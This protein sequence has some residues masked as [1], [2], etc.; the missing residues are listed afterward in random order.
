MSEKPEPSTVPEDEEIPL[1]EEEDAT[2]PNPTEENQNEAEAGDTPLSEWTEIMS[3]LART[4]PPICGVLNGSRAF[5]KGQFL[6]IDAPNPMFRGMIN[7]KSSTYRDAIRKAAEQVLGQTYKL[8]PYKASATDTSN[9][10]LKALADKLKQ[11]D[12][13]NN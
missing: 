13:P 7:G 2:P 11:F 12:I 10:P 1:P 6:L 5:I 3:I 9:D 8:G 4:S